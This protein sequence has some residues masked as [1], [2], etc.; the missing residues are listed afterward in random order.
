[1][2]LALCNAKEAREGGE[3]VRGADQE[4]RKSHC[5]KPT[6]LEVPFGVVQLNVLNVLCSVAASISMQALF[7]TRLAP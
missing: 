6:L 2:C 3:A 7:S 5:E 4:K 1:M